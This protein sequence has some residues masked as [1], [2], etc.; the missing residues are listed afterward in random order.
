MKIRPIICSCTGIVYIYALP[1]WSS[2]LFVESV[3]TINAFFGVF[4]G[5][6]PIRTVR[7]Q[8]MK[9]MHRND[10]DLFCNMCKMP[11]HCLNHLCLFGKFHNTVFA[12]IATVLN[13]HPVILMNRVL[14]K[15]VLNFYSVLYFLYIYYF[16]TCVCCNKTIIKK[17]T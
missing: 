10:N 12:N 14:C 17:F 7:L 8:C 5:M 3:N 11:E 1:A 4:E 15:F 2:F 6:T 9:L 13:F 16:L